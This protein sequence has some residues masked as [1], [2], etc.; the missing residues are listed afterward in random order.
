[1]DFDID[2]FLNE[3]FKKV[4]KKDKKKINENK[5]NQINDSIKE[6]NIKTNTISII[7]VIK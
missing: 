2:S 3:T 6:E 5:I 7:E 4:E 1:M